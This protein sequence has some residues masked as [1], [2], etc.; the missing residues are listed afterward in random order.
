MT[1]VDSSLKADGDLRLWD[2][3]E[4]TFSPCDGL[5]RELLH[6]AGVQNRTMSFW[7]PA[8]VPVSVITAATRQSDTLSSVRATL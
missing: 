5:M 7:H 4:M 8:A 3:H 2:A 6:L 1:A